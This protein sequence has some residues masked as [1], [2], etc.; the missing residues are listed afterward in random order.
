[1]SQ[2]AEWE[3]G[4]AH[5]LGTRMRLSLNCR[6]TV[7]GVTLGKEQDLPKMLFNLVY[8]VNIILASWVEVREGT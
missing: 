6:C 4:D 1:M 8:V 7:Y 3:S 2:D 5:A